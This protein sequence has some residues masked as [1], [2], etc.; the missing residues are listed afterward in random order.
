MN[1]VPFV[2]QKE[3]E[4]RKRKLADAEEKQRFKEEAKDLV[5]NF[6]TTDQFKFM[7]LNLIDS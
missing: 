7:Q 6:Y 2:F 4:D 5:I 3:A 1:G